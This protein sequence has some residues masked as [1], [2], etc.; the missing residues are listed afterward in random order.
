LDISIAS[1]KG[2]N[3]L[4]AFQLTTDMAEGARMDPI[5]RGSL[6]MVAHFDA[7]LTHPLNV[8]VYVQ[9]ATIIQID[10]ARNIITD[11]TPC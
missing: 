8:I 3:Y 10:K 4:C 6:R 7:T 5:T 1:F 11:F 2:G 9:F